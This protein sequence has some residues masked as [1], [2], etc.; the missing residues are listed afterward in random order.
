MDKE[1]EEILNST[2]R[3]DQKKNLKS[4][5]FHNTTSIIKTFIFIGLVSVMLILL[6]NSFNN[7]YNK[8]NHT[9]KVASLLNIG[10]PKQ[11]ATSG[12]ETIKISGSNIK[13]EY[14]ASYS[15]IGRVVST[16]NYYGFNI[17]DKISPMDIGLAWGWLSNKNV[18]LKI[19]WSLPKERYLYFYVSDGKWLNDNGGVNAIFP[20]FSNNHLIP[21]NNDIKNLMKSIKVN[22]YIKIEG[23]LVNAYSIKG[24]ESSF[25]TGTST[26]RTDDGNGACE[27]IYVTNITWLE[28]D[29]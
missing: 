2:R 23:Y 28:K 3:N 26:S 6:Y 1:W 16:R 19:N 21:S 11:T 4:K 18:D 27:T 14:L 10:T 25:I 8:K 12:S 29:K 15:I 17:R 24:N 22:D 5:I 13:V 9:Q 20:N 7:T